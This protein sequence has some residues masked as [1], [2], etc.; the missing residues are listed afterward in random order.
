MRRITSIQSCVGYTEFSAARRVE[1]LFPVCPSENY[2]VARKLDFSLPE[3][4]GEADYF[5]F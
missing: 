5:N 4:D 3:E 2:E 1:D